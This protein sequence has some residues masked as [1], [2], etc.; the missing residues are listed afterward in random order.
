MKFC[1][2]KWEH[3][4]CLAILS[5]LVGCATPP[6]G[7]KKELSD[8]PG[9]ASQGDVMR[10]TKR[11]TIELPENY[12]QETAFRKLNL[13]VQVKCDIN[14][15]RGIEYIFTPDESEEMG[16][17][18]SLD[19]QQYI[20]YL[21]RFNV[22]AAFG[23]GAR[24]LAAELED[25]GDVI[26]ATPENIRE[27]E[28]AMTCNLDVTFE[29]SRLGPAQAKE[30]GLR[31]GM[32]TLVANVKN[33]VVFTNPAREPL[34]SPVPWTVQS[35]PIGVF[36]DTNN[37]LRRGQMDFQSAIKDAIVRSLDQLRVFMGNQYP[38]SAKITGTAA[39]IDA[40]RMAIDKGVYHG[41]AK[42]TQG[43]VWARINGVDYP[44]GHADAQPA[45]K[46]GSIVVYEWST[47]SSGVKQVVEQIKTP[48]WLNNPGNELYWTS[49]ALERPPEWKLE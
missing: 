19:M 14:N 47:A 3:S 33:T 27:I 22:Y 42:N 34:P 32:S 43:V 23:D 7:P 29:Y 39:P 35:K 26:L 20:A 40:D 28:L 21:R 12:D 1:H 5:I 6:A 48:G 17:K 41:I 37:Q 18:A 25:V 10:N 30:L 9:R 31:P 38:V 45:E 8:S 16:F 4:V 36:V 24:D 13:L 44:M 2:S 49:M 15:V 46:R 11:K